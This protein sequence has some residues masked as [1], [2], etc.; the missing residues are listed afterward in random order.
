MPN[1]GR[2]SQDCHLCRRRRVKCDLARPGCQRCVK[3]G[4]ECPGYREQHE[5]V[6][7][8]ADPTAV[9]KRKKRAS[10]KVTEQ[11]GT[12][13]GSKA[14][15]SQA[16][17]SKATTSRAASTSSATTTV[18]ELDPNASLS[19]ALL[20]MPPSPAASSPSSLSSW[21][22]SS[23]SSSSSSDDT[24]PPLP[25]GLTDHWTNH[26]VPILLTI[27]STFGFLHDLYKT[28][29]GNGPLMWAAHLF[30]R[31]YVTNVR[32]PVHVCNESALET[33]RELGTYMGK[34]LSAVNAALNDPAGAFRDD[35][36][37]TV[38]IL[39]NYELLVGSVNR[40]GL[41]SPWHLHTR[42]LNSILQTRGVNQLNT[43]KGRMAFWPCYNIIQIQAMVSITECPPESDTWLG[44]IKNSLYEGEEHSL[45]VSVY[46]KTCTHI[47]A[48]VSGLLHQRDF[49]AAAA[50]YES[51]VQ[52]LEVAE[53]QVD[54]FLATGVDCTQELT[55]YLRNLYWG[56]V[57]KGHTYILYLA[58]FLT[59][60]PCGRLPPAQLSARRA[61]C[62]HKIRAAAQCII[63]SNLAALSSLRAQQDRSP[64]I[65]FDALR[66]VWSLTTVFVSAPALA[67]QRSQAQAALMFI[68]KEIGV[69]QALHTGV[70]GGALPPEA[71]LPLR[72]E[73]GEDATPAFAD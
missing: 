31:T 25:R 54:H 21:S 26:S 64:R 3:Y 42:G 4:V 38:W 29:P 60:D 68:G 52:Q 19:S 1:T 71:R 15:R 59:H 66:M 14:S 5:L 70:E 39:A 2:P 35:V 69:R 23:S 18:F 53:E 37:A 65:L 12:K 50:Q 67:E 34:T 72:L 57:I 41:S 44:I 10:A 7:R 16:S 13:A 49:A 24:R 63:E 22:S 11:A 46:I 30:S 20:S 45:H 62:L 56:A 17:G 40:A 9:A 36:L 6:F 47:M 43:L 51:L 28:N 61:H 73:V 8:N 33:Q 27:Y 48:A 32:Y 58:N 55:F